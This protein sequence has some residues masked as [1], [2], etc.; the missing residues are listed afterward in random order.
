M[1]FLRSMFG[2]DLTRDDARRYLV[3]AMLGAMAADGDVQDEEM[4]VL[5]DTVET[6]ALFEGLS[7]ESDE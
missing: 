7:Q 6:H 2:G 4:Q 5:Y 3:E 1:G